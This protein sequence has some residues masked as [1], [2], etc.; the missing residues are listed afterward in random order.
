M[1]SNEPASPA[2]PLW[3]APLFVLGVG[4]LVGLGCYLAGPVVAATIS[5]FS[6]SLLAWVGWMLKHV[7]RVLSWGAQAPDVMV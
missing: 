2:R 5:G 7:G 4:A 1:R 6:S 3:Q